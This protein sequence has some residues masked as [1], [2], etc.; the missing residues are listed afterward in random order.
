[1]SDTVA[2]TNAVLKRRVS[3]SIAEDWKQR[4]LVQDVTGGERFRDT[5]QDFA[6]EDL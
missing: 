4:S 2:V 6:K 3:D 5:R 1:M